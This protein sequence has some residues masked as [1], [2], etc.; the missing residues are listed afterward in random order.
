MAGR[1][2]YAALL[3]LRQ[4]V[5]AP[6]ASVP[7]NR[8]YLSPDRADAFVESFLRF[9]HGR[10]V[11]DDRQASGVEIGRPDVAHRRIRIEADF[12]KLTGFVTGDHLPFPYGRETT[13]YEVADLNDMLVRAK[14]AGVEVLV[15][16]FT[17]DERRSVM[18]EFPGGYIAEIHAPARP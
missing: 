6:L 16:P 12:G 11:S 1:R 4:T 9:S 17:N 3:A 5:L 18:V 13:G 15:E 10:T 2:R 7:E 8:A 14:S